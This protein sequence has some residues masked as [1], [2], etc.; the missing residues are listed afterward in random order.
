MIRPLRLPGG[1]LMK[2][3][4][5]SEYYRMGGVAQAKGAEKKT[6]QRALNLAVLSSF[7][8]EG[9]KEVLH[10]KC[11]RAGIQ[12]QVY[13]SDYNQYAQ[14]ILNP[15]SALYQS[16]PGLVILFIDT[17]SL[18][19]D[20]YFFPYRLNTAQRKELADEKL[21][22]IQSYIRALRENSKAKVLVHNFQVPAYSPLGILED[23]QDYGFHEM[24]RDLNSRLQHAYKQN[25]DV[26]V[27]D[28]EGFCS[29]FGKN[30]IVDSK[31]YY[32][33]DVRLKFNLLPELGEAYLG[34]IKP[35][36]GLSK[37][38][39]VLDLDN[40]LW[41]GIV[42]EDSL[43]GLELGH[44]PQGRPYLEF[45][46]HLLHLS[47]RG[48]LLAVNSRNNPE[49]ALR[50]FREHPEMILREEHF[51]CMKINWGDKVTNLKAIA[52]ELNIGL[53]AMVFVD[54]DRINRE[55][56]RQALPEVC[57]VDLPQDSSLYVETLLGMNEF[58][59]MNIT[60]ED[61][62]R[63][64]MYSQEKKRKA[65]QTDSSDL[66]DFLRVLQIKVTFS[67]PSTLLVPRIA[68]L[69]QKTNQ[70][71]MTT[72]R[73][74]TGDIRRLADDPKSFLMAV[75]RA[76]DKFGDNGITGTAIV[77]KKGRVW[78]IDSFLLSC[79]ILGRGIEECLLAY[80]VESGRQEKARRL[81][82]EFVRTAKNQPAAG[83]YKQ[84]GF[85]LTHEDG[86]HQQWEYDLSKPYDYPGFIQVV[87]ER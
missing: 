58:H 8:T 9:V 86:N 41:G 43:E 64:Q 34:W 54:D 6:P 71:N 24:I 45:Q 76:E 39:L 11:E 69:T 33:G 10:V 60:D 30:Q 74:Q 46:K 72:K 13:Q 52:Q 38:C 85:Q 35:L 77:E 44:T 27:F 18:L 22:E 66:T 14:D 2:P 53:D 79:R 12:A 65:L 87:K 32:L 57:V 42:G 67:K 20:H 55:L 84:N 49:D 59:V 82:G 23:E 78:R 37:K 47:E 5:F 68:Q 36:L 63:T 80:L 4:E 48:V 81:T 51:A 3:E 61:K 16:N 29:R 15:K 26:F 70:F 21:S 19:G 62:R 40:T 7:T 73:Y 1:R 56:V 17:Q 28:Y 75:L 31:M 50:V 25:Q 83:F